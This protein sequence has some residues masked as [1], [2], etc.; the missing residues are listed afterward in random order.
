MNDYAERELTLAA[1]APPKEEGVE[2]AEAIGG[3]IQT[4]YAT[5]QETAAARLA[6]TRRKWQAEAEAA[7]KQ[8]AEAQAA[9][10]AKIAD[11]HSGAVSKLWKRLSSEDADW[12]LTGAQANAAL[13]AARIQAEATLTAAYIIAEAIEGIVPSWGNAR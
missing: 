4:D 3:K 9:E 10:F 2:D 6:E 12:E 5:R 13:D 8:E 7:A 1:N 11:I